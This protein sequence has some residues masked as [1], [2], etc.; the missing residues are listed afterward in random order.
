MI[1][2]ARLLRSLIWSSLSLCK[3]GLR[4]ISA[5]FDLMGGKKVATVLPVLIVGESI[6]RLKILKKSE[7]LKSALPQK[8]L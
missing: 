4:A 8:P 3:Q 6:L 2:Q 1:R 5:M 7:L